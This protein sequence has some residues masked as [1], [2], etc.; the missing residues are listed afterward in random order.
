MLR[1][2]NDRHNE[3]AAAGKILWRQNAMNTVPARTGPRLTKFD[4]KHMRVLCQA[5]GIEA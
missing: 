4:L 2:E 3:R 5:L 1:G